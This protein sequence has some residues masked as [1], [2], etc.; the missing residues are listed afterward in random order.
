MYFGGGPPVAGASTPFTLAGSAAGP[1]TLA[2]GVQIGGTGELSY[3]RATAFP[4]APNQGTWAKQGQINSMPNP[5]DV[6]GVEVWGPEPGFKA[7]AE[8]YSLHTDFNTNTSV[9]SLDLGTNTSTP[10][11]SRATIDAAVTA[12]LGP[13]PATAVFPY[14]GPDPLVGIDAINLDALMVQDIIN[15]GT[16]GPDTFDRDPAGVIGD[17]II[18]SISQIPDPQD[19]DGYYA[20][21]SELFVLDA[22]HPTTPQFLFHGGHF[23]DQTYALNNLLV[24]PN[25]IDNGYAVIDVNAIEAISEGVV[26]EPAS[27]MLLLLGVGAIGI[28]GRRR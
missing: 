5:N 23:W 4:M 13:V 2:N 24:S 3:E 1:F 14:S 27:A 28:A 25:I 10:Y 11:I 26:P 8:K 18:F 9:W 15:D 21:G 22:S 12:L 16:G 7:D 20:T 17:R 6:D 19:P